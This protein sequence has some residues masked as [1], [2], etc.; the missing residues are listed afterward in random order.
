M[1]GTLL[2]RA[3]SL[4]SEAHELYEGA[5]LRRTLSA[6]G[7][8]HATGSYALDLMT[9]RDLDL[10]LE[11]ADLAPGWFFRLGGEIA[12]LLRPVRMSY[13]D[14]RPER[15]GR[16]ERLPPGLYWGI[17][18]EATAEEGWKVDLWALRPADCARLLAVRDAIARALDPTSRRRILRIKGHLWRDPR[19][20]REFHSTDIYGAVL[21]HGVTDVPGF[22]AYLAA[23]LA[24]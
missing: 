8:P 7:T 17:Y 10:Y 9:W 5:G 23:R 4:R 3:A 20:R 13:R 14:E 19:Y 12:E 11:V 18:L 24:D 2:A 22:L 15:S 1:D 6:Y 16:D 21:R